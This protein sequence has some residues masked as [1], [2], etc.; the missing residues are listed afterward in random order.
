MIR[1]GWNDR[2][3]RGHAR[4]EGMKRFL[5]HSVRVFDTCTII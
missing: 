2:L 5:A 4:R 1:C 3:I